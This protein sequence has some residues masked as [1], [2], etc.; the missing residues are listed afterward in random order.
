MDLLVSQR[1]RT[2]ACTKCTTCL[3]VCPVAARVER[4]PGPMA[5][6]P[7][8]QRLRSET[9]P[10]LDG[11]TDYCL[12]CKACDVACPSGVRVSELNTLARAAYVQRYGARLRD[13]MLGHAYLLGQMSTRVAPL[14]N[15]ALSL[16][17]LR[18]LLEKTFQVDRRRP[19]PRYQATTFRRWF[20]RR[21]VL[22]RER[23]VAYFVGCAADQ[24]EVSVARAVVSVL[25]RN[26]FQVIVPPQT[27]CG[28]PLMANG[29]I[30]GA[31]SYARRNID[32]LRDVVERGLPIVTS[33]VSCGLMLRS[34]YETVLGLREARPLAAQTFDIF[35]FLLLLKDEG[36]LDTTFQPIPASL[37]YHQSCHQRALGI[38][39]PAIDVLN[40]VPGLRVAM[41]DS[42]CC[43]NPGTYG[44]KTEKYDLTM[45]IGRQLFEAIAKAGS[46]TVLSDCET[47][48]WQIAH[49]G[50]VS[51]IHPIEVLARAYD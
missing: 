47:C 3:D 16:S 19:F 46:D 36:Q 30:E 20:A 44:F 24:T 29:D 45:Q 49:G 50:G 28:L 2:D 17:P 25:E 42:G 48:R 1:Y 51:A 6:G 39:T 31:R 8:T 21:P 34:E 5:G 37:P 10:I 14:A 11:A 26:G 35:E 18:W 15:R 41:M 9:R 33:S 4:F 22:E 40:A 13:R 7:Q 12:N 38:G 23:Q 32:A 27:C 43:G